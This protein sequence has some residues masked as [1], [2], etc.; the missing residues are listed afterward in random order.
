MGAQEDSSL[1]ATIKVKLPI[2]DPCSIVAK[3][4]LIGHHPFKEFRSNGA[5]W[6]WVSQSGKKEKNVTL[7]EEKSSGWTRVAREGRKN[8]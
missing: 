5:F 4:N 6:P 1:I 2:I 7:E 8:R 3:E